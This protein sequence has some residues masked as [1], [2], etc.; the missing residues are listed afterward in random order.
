MVLR[1]GEQ[2]LIRSEARAQQNDLSGSESDINIIRSRALLSG[3]SNL[4]RD[5]LLDTIAHER[6]VELFCE[7]GHRWFDLKRT[8]K[9]SAILRPIK[10]N[11]NDYA[12]LY[13]I[14][15]TELA[16]DPNLTQ[17]PGY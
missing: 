10:P 9:L 13:P 3:I 7:W 1:L 5:E 6:Q 4:S 14:P 16:N 17:N 12:Q 15:V 11:W 2:Y 8:G